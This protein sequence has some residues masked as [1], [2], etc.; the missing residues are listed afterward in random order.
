MAG[1]RLDVN[2]RPMEVSFRETLTSS[3]AVS[4]NRTP[5]VIPQDEPLPTGPIRVGGRSRQGQL[6]ASLHKEHQEIGPRPD[7]QG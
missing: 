5:A 4:A 1:D 3:A 2:F 6:V 7:R